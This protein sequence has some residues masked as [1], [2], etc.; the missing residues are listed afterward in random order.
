MSNF[1]VTPMVCPKCGKN[2]HLV[3]NPDGDEHFNCD[4]CGH[5]LPEVKPNHPH[6]GGGGIRG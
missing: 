1:M 3:I 4:A 5:T 6:R 2:G